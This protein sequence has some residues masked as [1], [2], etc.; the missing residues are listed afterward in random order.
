M[1]RREM[2]RTAVECLIALESLGFEIEIVSDF[3][4]VANV[5]SSLESEIGAAHDHR[6]L[7]LT[8]G[9]AF[10]VFAH[11]CGRPVA[12]FGVRMDDL[13]GENAELFL[14]RSIEVVF[15]VSVTK[16]RSDIFA[17]ATWGRAAYFGGFVSKA[18]RGLSKEGRYMIQLLTAYVHHCA[19]R[20]LGSDV[21][22]CFLRGADCSRGVPYGFL[23]ADPFVWETNR[24]MYSDGNPE[25]VM[26]L[27]RER[28]PSLMTA[29]AELL[30]QRFAENQQS[31]FPVEIKN[32][33][34]G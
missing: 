23:Q 12:A 30:R 31:L 16:R 24:P 5:L 18:A 15:D 25:W 1:H 26:Q 11:R 33:A 9:N 28:M 14:Q 32:A 17:R 22:Y 6:R 27:S 21:N 13:G 29:M 19:F 10:W 2:E 8:P 4:R 7:L 20:D 3:S 34:S